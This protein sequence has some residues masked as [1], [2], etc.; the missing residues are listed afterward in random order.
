MQCGQR[1]EG[2]RVKPLCLLSELTVPYAS[3]ACGKRGKGDSQVFMGQ[4]PGAISMSGVIE[5]T[6]LYLKVQ[7]VYLTHILSLERRPNLGLRVI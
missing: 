1:W 6:L 3:F 4:D 7:S 5:T 2:E